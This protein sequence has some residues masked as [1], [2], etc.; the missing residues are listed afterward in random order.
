MSLYKLKSI[1]WKDL[2]R[3]RC[4]ARIHDGRNQIIEKFRK[5]SITDDVVADKYVDED[6]IDYESIMNE[7]W[8]KL[9]IEHSNDLFMSNSELEK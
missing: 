5:I 4:R 2:Y 7:E 8:Q 6:E 3:D 1:N 9:Q